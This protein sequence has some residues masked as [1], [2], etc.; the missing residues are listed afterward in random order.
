MYKKLVT[1]IRE[2]PWG[3]YDPKAIIYLSLCSAVEFAESLRLALIAYP[4]NQNLG[5]MAN[6]ELKTNNLS[7]DD[8][9]TYGDHSEFLAH[10]CKKHNIT[11][12]SIGDKCFFAKKDYSRAVRNLGDNKVRA[13]TIFSREQEL[14]DIFHKIVKAHDWDALGLGFFK[15]Y[16][17]RHIAID[18]ED[19]GHG[20]LTK[21]FQIDEEMLFK[22]YTIRLNL[23]KSLHCNVTKSSSWDAVLQFT[24]QNPGKKIEGFLGSVPFPTMYGG[25]EYE[26]IAIDGEKYTARV[27]DAREFMSEGLEWK[28]LG[29]NRNGNIEKY[30][31]VAWKLVE[32]S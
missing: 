5:E 27:D 28:T 9:A 3:Q 29:E 24:E 13:M 15:Y 8:Y 17:E 11:D 26:I 31:I 10:F 6:G 21:S 20:D 22:F 7:Y 1:E 32:K 30:Y 14:P 25:Q 4:Q 19:G 18:S 12:N 23:Y 2:L 16:L